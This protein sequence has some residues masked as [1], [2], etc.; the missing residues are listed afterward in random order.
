M[1]LITIEQIERAINIW[2]ARHPTPE[3]T[4]EC[5]TLCAEA[6][7]LANVYAAM[8]FNRETFI[9]AARLNASQAVGL[10]RALDAR[11]N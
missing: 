10:Q 1:S 6:R 8:I 2:R 9:D 11:K 4:N 5:P 3:G 7:E